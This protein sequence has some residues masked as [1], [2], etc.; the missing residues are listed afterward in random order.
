MTTQQ[1]LMIPTETNVVENICVWDGDVNTWQPPS[2]TLMLV[3]SETQSIV[4]EAVVIDNKI[5]NYEPT[6]KYIRSAF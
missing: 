4:W 1:Y 3:Q 6:K 5:T 2:N